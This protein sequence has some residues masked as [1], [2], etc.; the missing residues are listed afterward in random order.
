VCIRESRCFCFH[1]ASRTT[2]FRYFIL[3]FDM[4]VNLCKKEFFVQYKHCKLS[5]RSACFFF[6]GQHP[7]L[8]KGPKLM[9]K[10]GNGLH[11]EAVREHFYYFLNYLWGLLLTFPTK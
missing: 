2:A 7:S 4:K 5:L 8:G 1:L 9:V 10:N 6:C 3:E 11:K